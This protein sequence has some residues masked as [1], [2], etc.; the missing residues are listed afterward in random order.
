[1]QQETACKSETIILTTFDLEGMIEISLK[2]YSRFVGT[3]S[4]EEHLNQGN[5]QV[6]ECSRIFLEQSNHHKEGKFFK[7]Y[8]TV[9]TL[10][11]TKK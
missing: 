6:N 7:Y 9:F 5:L 2:F 3:V 10:D 11:K 1:M 4:R 8:L